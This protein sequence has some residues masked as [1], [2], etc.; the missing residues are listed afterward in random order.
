MNA[1]PSATLIV[2]A[3]TAPTP[4]PAVK[5]E[6]GPSPSKYII[7][8]DAAGN[9]HAILFHHKLQHNTMVPANMVPV[10]AGFVMVL[11]GIM[12]IPDIDSTT[13]NLGPRPQDKQ[14][15]SK[16]INL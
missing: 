9:E 12:I 4:P 16:L 2:R 10:S 14:I 7:V 13:L 5:A 3:A 6:S 11:S 1:L 8:G 15:L